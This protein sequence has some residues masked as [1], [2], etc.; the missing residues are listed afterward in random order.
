M[1]SL[2]SPNT[3]ILGLHPSPIPR[4]SPT[5]NC[6]RTLHRA[7]SCMRKI[8]FLGKKMHFSEACL[9]FLSPKF[10]W[11]SNL[12]RLSNNTD[13]SQLTNLKSYYRRDVKIN[14]KYGRA[15]WK[16]FVDMR[17]VVVTR[18]GVFFH[19]TIPCQKMSSP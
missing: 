11:S 2:P 14:G 19:A 9:G 1:K 12:D 8:F 17:Q 18:S 10:D 16:I 6:S 4:Y 13:I 3:T 15:S 7:F 5:Q